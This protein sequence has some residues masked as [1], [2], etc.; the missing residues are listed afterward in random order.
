M[1]LLVFGGVALS[2]R[3]RSVAEVEVEVEVE[4]GAAVAQWSCSLEHREA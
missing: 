1:H 2:Q 4:E 3:Q